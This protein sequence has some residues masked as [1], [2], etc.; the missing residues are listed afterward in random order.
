MKLDYEDYEE[1]EQDEDDEEEAEPS[2]TSSGDEFEDAMEK[3]T[4]SDAT[5]ETQ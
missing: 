3:L 2:E 4:V 5:T 1:E